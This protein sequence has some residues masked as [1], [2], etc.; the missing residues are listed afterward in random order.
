MA[1]RFR[2]PVVIAGLV[3]TLAIMLLGSVAVDPASF[4]DDPS[5]V[6]VSVA[7]VIG[8]VV[9]TLSLSDTEMAL[10]EDARVDHLTGLSNRASLAPRFGE[11]RAQRA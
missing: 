2:R 8:V 6:L 10:R 5:L 7:L 9:F 11:L 3:A 1:N 4:A